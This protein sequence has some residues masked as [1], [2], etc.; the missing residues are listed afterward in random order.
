M[1]AAAGGNLSEIISTSHCIWAE[2]VLFLV[3]PQ[4]NDRPAGLGC[5]CKLYAVI[6]QAWQDF[7]NQMGVTQ[8]QADTNRRTPLRSVFL[9][10][11]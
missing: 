1:A 5:V 11:S 10:V 6:R 2:L 3:I 8:T 4:I 9:L 7:E